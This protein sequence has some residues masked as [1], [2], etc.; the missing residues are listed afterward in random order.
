[1]SFYVEVERINGRYGLA[2]ISAKILDRGFEDR[3][4]YNEGGWYDTETTTVKPH[5]KF[6]HEDDALAYVLAFGGVISRKIPTIPFIQ[7]Y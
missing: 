6:E 3:I 4:S 5:L 2:E 7:T 1:M